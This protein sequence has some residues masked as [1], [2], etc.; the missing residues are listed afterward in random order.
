MKQKIT[1]ERQNYKTNYCSTHSDIAKFHKS[2]PIV[3]C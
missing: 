1:I 3:Q 2:W